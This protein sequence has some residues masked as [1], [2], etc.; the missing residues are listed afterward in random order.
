MGPL[1]PV[2]PGPSIAVTDA[3]TAGHCN[4]DADA[5]A[6]GQPHP[7]AQSD[8]DAL[9]PRHSPHGGFVKRSMTNL[10]AAMPLLRAVVLAGLAIAL[11]MFGLPA[12]LGF[13]AVAAP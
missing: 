5:L 7:F 10:R 3:P 13:A 4:T 2:L 6:Y 12:I 8:P 9:A 11:I 1:A